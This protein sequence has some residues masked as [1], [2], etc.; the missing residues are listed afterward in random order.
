[1]TNNA[2]VVALH[3]EDRVPT[4]L[5]RELFTRAF[6][7]LTRNGTARIPSKHLVDKLVALGIP[8]AERAMEVIEAHTALG[9]GL[10]PL[11][12]GGKPSL[13]WLV[14]KHWEKSPDELIARIR[15]YYPAVEVGEIIAELRKQAAAAQAE[16]AAM[17][18]EIDAMEV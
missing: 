7:E 11:Q 17:E 1:M 14:R 18:A 13:S 3:D 12:E 15:K 6:D 4:P 2:T 16:A 9:G 8:T 5:E 10:P